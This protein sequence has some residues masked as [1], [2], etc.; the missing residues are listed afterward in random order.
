MD[1]RILIRDNVSV[2]QGIEG[3]PERDLQR[4]ISGKK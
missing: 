2:I 4:M 3:M 1:K